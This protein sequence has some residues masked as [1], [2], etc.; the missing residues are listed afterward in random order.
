[1]A[2]QP[3]P[4][5]TTV[6]LSVPFCTMTR[7]ALWKD[8]GPVTPAGV[9]VAA[10]VAAPAAPAAEAATGVVA[11]A[12]ALMEEESIARA[13]TPVDLFARTLCAVESILGRRGMRSRVVIYVY[14]GRRG[15]GEMPGDAFFI[16]EFWFRRSTREGP[17]IGPGNFAKKRRKNKLRGG[18]RTVGSFGCHAGPGGCNVWL[19]PVGSGLRGTQLVQ[20]CPGRTNRF[21]T[22]IP[23][24]LK[25]SI[26]DWFTGRAPPPTNSVFRCMAGGRG[27]RWEWR[28]RRGTE[29]MC[30]VRIGRCW[31]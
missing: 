17:L 6:G 13:A 15:E 4:R 14:M 7:G 12:M 23:A 25:F 5:T 22:G 10:A 27:F 16:C 9:A 21:P 8:P 24:R 2:P 26:S 20:L 18:G 30:V 3:D 28:V 31:V 11:V 19:P 29:V 1:M